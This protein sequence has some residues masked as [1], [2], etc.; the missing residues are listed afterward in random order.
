MRTAGAAIALCASVLFMGQ[1]PMPKPPPPDPFGPPQR[2]WAR[3]AEGRSW[4]QSAGIE[5]GP[6]GEIWAIDR[7]GANSC[8]GSNLPAIHQLDP[9]TGRPIRS[10]GAGLF[11]FPHGLHVDRDGNIWVTDAAISKDKS[12]GQQVIKLSPE[13]KVL[14]RLGTAGVSAGGPTHFHNPGDVVTAPNGDIFVA[15]GHGTVAMDLPPNTITRIV[16]FTPDGKFIKAWGSLG[17]GKSQFRNPHALAFDSQGR[18]FVADRVNGRI[19]IFDQDGKW[20]TQYRS[21]NH[22][23]GLYID[24]NDMLYASDYNSDGQK[25]VY[26]GSAKTGKLIYFVP[27]DQAGEGVALGPDGTLYEATPTGITRFLPR[28]TQ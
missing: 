2:Q 10:I 16:K 17:S 13:G 18:L 24:K 21:F 23:S 28:K 25:G 19:Q 20:L 7:C 27:D 12:K 4:G 6:H 26:I 3:P 14:M 11:A 1:M 8:D 15:D 22:P 9:K 5:I